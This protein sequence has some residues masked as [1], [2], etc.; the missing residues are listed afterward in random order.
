MRKT[1]QPIADTDD[2]IIHSVYSYYIEHKDIGKK[3]YDFS[4]SKDFDSIYQQI[5]VSDAEK[6]FP[7]VAVVVLTANKYERNVLHSIYFNKTGNRIER[8][9]IELFPDLVDIASYGYL[10]EWHGYLI[11]NLHAST[12]GSYTIGGSADLV[13][14]VGTKYSLSPAIIISCGIC[15]GVDHNSQELGSTYLS[16]K[17]YPYFMG[18]KITKDELFT[19]DDNMFKSDW[20]LIHNLRGKYFDVN[21]YKDIYDEDTPEFVFKIG[22]F[23]T[24][25]AVVSNQEFRD[26]FVD[27]TTQQVK[28]GEME[29]YGM[30][31]ECSFIRIPCL[32]IKSICDWG[33]AKNDS[34]PDIFEELNGSPAEK[35]ELSSIKDCIQAMAA[36]NA[37]KALESLLRNKMFNKSLYDIIKDWIIKEYK[38]PGIFLETIQERY[39]GILT[40]QRR[41]VNYENADHFVLA[42]IDALKRDKILKSPD[43]T[44]NMWIIAR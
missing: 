25:E 12:T 1:H 13:R 8:F 3:Y 32:T 39:K 35:G 33:A 37:A 20:Y 11:L 31:K 16:E 43:D 41:A 30:Y 9:D 22:N 34:N 26:F 42:T 10:F 19:S 24:G 2:E 7:K 4:E 15:F 6:L 17:V 28:A 21:K 38:E 44:D 14:Y 5:D 29:A 36:S 40:D 23:I 18:S 27:V